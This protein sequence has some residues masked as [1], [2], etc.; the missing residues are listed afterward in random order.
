MKESN[1]RFQPISINR[2]YT[3]EMVPGQGRERKEIF[4]TSQQ[5]SLEL[6]DFDIYEK[7]QVTLIENDFDQF[8]GNFLSTEQT[9]GE[10]EALRRAMQ[11]A[12]KKAEIIVQEA[13]LKLGGIQSV[14]YHDV[15]YM[16]RQQVES[17]AVRADSQSLMQYEQTVVVRASVT[18][19][20]LIE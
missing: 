14:N 20:F 6:S 15:Q 10:D 16:P 5:V 13:N 9:E 17:M 7:I 18:V 8:S 11:Q 1:I 3:D 19:Q 2:S 12:Q 4:R